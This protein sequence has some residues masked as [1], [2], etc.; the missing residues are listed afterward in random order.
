MR[1]SRRVVP[2]RL[3]TRLALA[4][5]VVAIV[6]VAILTAAFNLLLDARLH[7]QAD[8][9][10][11][12]R[13]A[14]VAATIA[15][16]PD[17]QLRIAEPT[18]DHALDS[19][20]WIYQGQAV[21]EQP[22]T[23]SPLGR[24]ADAL[25][26]RRNTFVDVAGFR[27]YARAVDST[28]GRQSGTVVVAVALDAYRSSARSALL[29]SLLCG[30]LIVASAYPV[31]L[32]LVRRSLRPVASMSAHAAVWS[33][34]GATNRFGDVGRPEE[35]QVLAT[36]LDT[37]L[38]RL[39]AALRQERLRTAELSHE[40]RTPLALIVAEL[41]WLRSAERHRAQREASH[42]AVLLAA[43]RMQGICETLLSAPVGGGI[44]DTRQIAD[45]AIAQVHFDSGLRLEVDGPSLV[46]AAPSAVVERIL[47]V[48][49]E[50]AGRYAASFGARELGRR[51]QHRPHQRPQRW[52][53][54]R[55]IRRRIDFPTRRPP[56]SG[57]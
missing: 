37:L 21:R 27:L 39:A 41:E 53:W 36:N 16:G 30:G 45:L 18:D 25:A 56:R 31:T 10:L 9:V 8:D 44:C 40:L 1:Q 47:A 48:L 35:L 7:A 17:G 3:Q 20:V 15:S 38:D 13:S 4:A 54:Y 42:E 14:A 2:G 22:A 29:A 32:R 43:Q 50:N 12:T 11:R 24:A 49:L 34:A 19:G 33:E 26:G 28:G 51:R 6:W 23:S 57:R 52:T 5:L 46:A 55:G